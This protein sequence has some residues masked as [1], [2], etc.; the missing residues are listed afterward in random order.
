MVPTGEDMQE[1][2]QLLQNDN[3]D[4]DHAEE[5]NED[6]EEE[7]N[8]KEDEDDEDYTPF[9]DFEKKKEYHIADEIKTF[10]N[11]AP[12]RTSRL[13]ELLNR[14]NITTPPEFRVKRVLRPG[15]E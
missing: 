13:R 12:I 9:S 10:G 6:E 3:H 7:D 2:Q 15:R 11:E 14:I 5:E 1:A 4:D 8:E